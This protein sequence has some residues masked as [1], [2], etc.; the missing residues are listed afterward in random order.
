LLGSK[1]EVK[2][3]SFDVIKTWPLNYLSFSKDFETKI[4]VFEAIGALQTFL[5]KNRVFLAKIGSLIFF[6]KSN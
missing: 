5:A 3:P 2:V 1:N 4:L 6:N